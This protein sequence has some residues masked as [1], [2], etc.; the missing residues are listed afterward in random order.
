MTPS[1][2]TADDAIATLRRHRIIPKR[3][4]AIS[5]VEAERKNGRQAY[6]VDTRD[7]RVLKARHL[8]DPELAQEVCE[9]RAGLDEGFAPV[10]IRD[11]AVLLE[12]WIDGVVL[13]DETAAPW[14]A[15]AGRLLGRLHIAPLG[16]GVAS[17][18]STDVWRHGA[19]GDLRILR[20]AGHVSEARSGAL[21]AAL[22]QLDP[23]T[24]RATKV[25]HDFCPENL[26]VDVRGRVFVIDNE[27][28]RIGVP[29]FDVGRTLCRWPMSP[30]AWQQFHD[31]YRHEAGPLEAFLFWRIVSAL[32]SARVQ[33]QVAPEGLDPV[34]GVL[35]ASVAL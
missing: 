19:Q 25:H 5:P 8:R 2:R 30:E 28:V 21:A 32:F 24:A 34:L 20:D 22:E 27:W 17:E 13:T 35:R 9:L 33:L 1:T 16:N 4:T 15:E 12:A 29:E 11:G 3:I 6:R 7:G 23:Q 31:G 26:V 18:R 10:L 14:A